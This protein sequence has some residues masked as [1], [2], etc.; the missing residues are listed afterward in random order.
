MYLKADARRD[1]KLSCDELES[2]NVSP[3]ALAPGPLGA[4]N[5]SVHAGGCGFQ[6]SYDE[7][8][9]GFRVH[10][11]IRPDQVSENASLDAQKP[12]CSLSLLHGEMDRDLK[13]NPRDLGKTLKTIADAKPRLDLKLGSIFSIPSIRPRHY[14]L[15]AQLDIHACPRHT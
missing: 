12:A 15:L 4:D 5:A 6:N 7:L 11:T 8:A 10:K 3:P 1:R 2:A 13:R 9:T 14:I